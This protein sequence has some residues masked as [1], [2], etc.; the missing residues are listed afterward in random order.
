MACMLEEQPL[1]SV[2]AVKVPGMC[3]LFSNYLEIN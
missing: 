2:A 1:P 3:L